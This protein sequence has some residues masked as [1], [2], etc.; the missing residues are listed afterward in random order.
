MLAVTVG[1]VPL[2]KSQYEPNANVL[3]ELACCVNTITPD[4]PAVRLVGLASVVFSVNVCVKLLSFMLTAIEAEVLVSATGV[5][6]PFLPVIV[7]N[8][9][10]AGVVDPRAAGA[11][12]SAPSS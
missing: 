7:V 5:P 2:G 9:P 4:C 10:A 12:Q 11:A 3:G 1:T 8:V 6:T